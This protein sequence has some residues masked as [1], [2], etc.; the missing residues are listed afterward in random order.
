MMYFYL[1]QMP[2]RTIQ[3][4]QYTIARYFYTIMYCCIMWITYVT[5]YSSFLIYDNVWLVLKTVP[6]FFACSAL[7]LLI[8]YK[9]DIKF[10]I[11]HSI[12]PPK[13]H[14]RI[15]KYCTFTTQKRTDTFSDLV[16]FCSFASCT[17]FVVYVKLQSS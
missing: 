3:T 10:A 16:V 13:R 15:E 4:I 9:Q 5:W 17:Y 8:L 7:L 6:I 12:F 14:C 1:H 11:F 2:C